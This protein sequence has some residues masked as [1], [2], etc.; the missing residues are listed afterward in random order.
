MLD[1]LRPPFEKIPDVRCAYNVGALFDI[2]TGRY[3][4]GRYG[5]S[6]LNGGYT[7]F[8]G[9]IGKP[10][11]FK[12]AI[13]DHFQ[14][15]LL[16][17]FLESVAGIFDTEIT[18]TKSGRAVRAERYAGLTG[19]NNPVWNDRLSITS[20]EIYLLDEWY[21]KLKEQA[22][23]KN[24]NRTKLLRVTPFLDRQG[25]PI[26]VMIPSSNFI[27]SFS[28][29]R[30]KGVEAMLLGNELGTS[31]Q[32]TSYMK[33]GGAK[34]RFL[35]ELP[36]LIATSAMPMILSAHVGKEIPMDARAI[37]EKKLGF[38]K[39]GDKIMEV[40]GDFLYLPTQVWQ[41]LS[42]NPLKND[43]TKAPEYPNGPGD[44]MKDDTDLMLINIMLL[45]N[46][47]GRSGLMMQVIASQE[48][49]LMPHLTQFHYIKTC[50]R[51]G[52]EGNDRNYT[53]SF[54]PDVALARTTIRPKLE[55]NPQLRR[56]VEITSEM[57][58]MFMLWDSAKPY[59]C[60]PKQLYDDL[61]A[62]G[63]DWDILL[64]TRG[65]WTFDNDQHE[66]PY[67]STMDLLRMKKGEYHPYWL[68]EDKKTVLT[69]GQIKSAVVK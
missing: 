52:M 29:A 54:L 23:N 57:C 26:S 60:T 16:S 58:Q 25:N 68:S 61:K 35:S 38:M 18:V 31:E 2:P 44:D 1:I 49:G 6:I 3:E 46:K 65:W 15:C 9:V 63:Y 4:T 12:S 53:L 40:S 21:E 42:A 62:K 34:K 19:E 59:E 30:T 36:K 48:L 14:F 50:D 27:D 64:N 17:N 43:S 67:L 56:A 22:E 33:E 55:S 41:T 13:G 24:K 51:F 66:I 8:V 69:P 45:R 39:Q 10:N 37:P 11:T 20:Q 5:E 28:K 32:N 7:P 47:T